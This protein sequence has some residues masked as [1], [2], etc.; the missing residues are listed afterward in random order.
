[1]YHTHTHARTHAHRWGRTR[2]RHQSA[3]GVLTDD[4]SMAEITFDKDLHEGALALTLA[5]EAYRADGD[6]DDLGDDH[7]LSQHQLP[8]PTHGGHHHHAGQRGEES[9]LLQ[10]GCLAG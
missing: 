9:A 6:E 10:V 1:M 7:G 4:D 2:P 5:H 8:L 3:D